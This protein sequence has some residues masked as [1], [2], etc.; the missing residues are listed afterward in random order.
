MDISCP[1]TT[2][3]YLLCS[4]NTLPSSPNSPGASLHQIHGFLPPSMHFDPPSAI[5]KTCGNVLTL[6]LTGPPSSLSATNTKSSSCLPKRVQLQ[7]RILSIRQP[8]TSSANN[9]QTHTPQN[10]LTATH[11]FSWDFTCRQLCFFF[12]RQNIQTP[13]ISHQQPRYIISAL[14]LS[15]CH[16]PDFSVFTHAS[17]SEIHKIMSNCRKK[18]SD[19]DP[20]LTWLLKECS[21]VVVPTIINIVNLSLTLGPFHPT[22]K[23]SEMSPLLNIPTSDK[24]KLSN[25]RPISNLSLIS[26]IIERAKSH[27]MDHLTSNSLPGFHQLAYC[28][29][30]STETALLYTHTRGVAR[31]KYVVWTDM[32]ARSVWNRLASQ[33]RTLT[34]PTPPYLSPCK[35]SS[36]LYQFQE[37]PLAKVGWTCPPQSTLWQR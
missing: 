28:K 15:S 7:P 13:S 35:K 3:H 6:L 12:Q 29:H 16:P 17:E 18:Q 19:L 30:H 34:G 33:V 22:V 9:Q 11:H 25:Y 14:A 5:L 8:Q 37:R 32:R 27:I 31:S 2:P 21:S 10:H 20:I 23:E 36:D 26:K 1:L 4:T 24:E